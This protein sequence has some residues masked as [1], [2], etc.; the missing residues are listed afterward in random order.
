MQNQVALI[1]VS[2][3]IIA[4]APPIVEHACE[5]LAQGVTPDVDNLS[6]VCHPIS[7]AEE[8]RNFVTKVEVEA[9]VL[10]EKE[11]ASSM[12]ACLSFRPLYPASIATKLYLVGYTM[13][14]F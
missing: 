9:L 10:R 11:R 14:N 12:A 5:E 1:L 13:P 8:S 6:V 2:V 7:V 3:R 4:P